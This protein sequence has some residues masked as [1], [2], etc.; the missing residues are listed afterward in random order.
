MFQINSQNG[1]VK[2]IKK[3]FQKLSQLV[4]QKYLI[5]LDIIHGFYQNQILHNFI[6]K[7]NY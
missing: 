5:L 7:L 4:E 6:K 2:L 3:S 1:D